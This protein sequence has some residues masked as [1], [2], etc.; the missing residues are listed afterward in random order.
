LSHFDNI[1]ILRIFLR[2]FSAKTAHKQI[3]TL[4]VKYVSELTNK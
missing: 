3:G 4:V 2:I 1:P